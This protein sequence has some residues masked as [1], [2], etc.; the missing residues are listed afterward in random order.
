MSCMDC[1]CNGWDIRQVVAG[2][3]NWLYEAQMGAMG[4]DG[5]GVTLNM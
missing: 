1:R 4:C 3:H 2:A 5:S